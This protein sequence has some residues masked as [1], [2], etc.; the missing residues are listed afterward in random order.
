[1][2]VGDHAMVRGAVRKPD[3][4]VGLRPSHRNPLFFGQPDETREAIPLASQVPDSH[5][6]RGHAFCAQCFEDRVDAVDPHDV[7]CS[8][9][10]RGGSILRL[11]MASDDRMFKPASGSA[12]GA[13]CA[14]TAGLILSVLR[15]LSGQPFPWPGRMPPPAP[16][17][18]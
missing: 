8:H 3:E 10:G 5:A 13:E 9:G 6:H 2:Y 12:L 4:L 18:R 14:H 16:D 17:S 7:S 11:P 1:A 15:V